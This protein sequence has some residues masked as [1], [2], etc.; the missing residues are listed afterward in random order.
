MCQPGLPNPQGDSQLGSFSFA[1][2]HNAKSSLFF[3]S[4]TKPT[5]VPLIK[6]SS[7]LPESSK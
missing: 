6:S 5:L 3:L 1:N 7:D 2:F 4:S